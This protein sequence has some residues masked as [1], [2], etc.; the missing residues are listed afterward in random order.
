MP[1]PNAWRELPL[2]ESQSM[3]VFISDPSSTTYAII[4]IMVAV[5]GGLYYRSRK[6]KD[7]FPLIGGAGVLL[8]LILIDFFVESPR[9][10]TMRKMNEMSAASAKKN[11][12]EVFTNVSDSFNYKG[13]G[14][15][16]QTD[17]KG[18][19]EK[20]RSVES[21]IEKGFVVWGFSRDDFKQINDNTAEIGFSSKV[22]DRDETTSYVKAV[23]TKDPD[24]QWR[25]SGFTCYEPIN[26]KERRNLP[27]L[28]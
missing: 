7:L 23:F 27:G 10:E 12:D 2:P 6:K 26:T 8:T 25:M 19:R 28:D 21:M 13:S 20:V 15:M 3:P 18:L 17:K 4:A 5:L 11:W 16:T 1:T 24:G 14:G 22:K 9:E